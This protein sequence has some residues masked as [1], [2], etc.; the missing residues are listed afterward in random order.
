MTEDSKRYLRNLRVLKQL[1]ILENA[2]FQ[3]KELKFAGCVPNQDEKCAIGR[4]Q[5]PCTS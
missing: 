3:K 2:N 5:I 1:L 4:G